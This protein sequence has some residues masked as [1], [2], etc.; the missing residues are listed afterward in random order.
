[1]G[2][3]ADMMGAVRRYKFTVADYERMG[4]AGL[5][6]KGPRVELLG[7]EIVEMSP[8]GSRHMAWVDKLARTLH[9]VCGGQAIVRTQG[10]VVLDDESEPEPDI[11]LLRPREDFYKHAH[12]EAPDILLAIE[13]ADSSLAFDR[14]VKAPLYAAAG[15]PQVWIIDVAAETIDVYEQ[16]LDGAYR[17]VHRAAPDEQLVLPVANRSSIIA[18]DVT[19]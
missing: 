18:A 16:P 5:F 15:V 3:D 10:P 11:A 12:P 13:V 6:A 9:A 1:M 8:M 14:E 2:K 17:R 7:G 4:E 19:P